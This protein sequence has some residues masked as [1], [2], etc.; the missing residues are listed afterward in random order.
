MSR[1]H[2]KDSLAGYTIRKD[3]LARYK[4]EREEEKGTTKEETESPT[5][6]F[7]KTL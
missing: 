6:A 3:S 4:R 2:S 7:G 1:L 5:F